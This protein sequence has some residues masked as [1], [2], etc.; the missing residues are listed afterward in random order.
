MENILNILA[1][2]ANEL[3]NNQAHRLADKVTIQLRTASEDDDHE[4][5]MV[6]NQMETAERAI[7]GIEDVIGD[8]GEG[9][10]MA[11]V[12]SKITNAV[13]MLDGVSDYLQSQHKTASDKNK[14]KKL[15]KPFRTP[16]GPKK[17][18]VYVKNDKGNIVKVNFGD[19]GLSIK[20]DNPARRKNFRARHNCDNP[21]P[22]W[23]ARYWSCRNWEAGRSV[24]DNLKGK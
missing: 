1:D 10:L 21:G 13:E 24:S 22:K 8:E 3:D 6:R 11:W 15:N 20:R 19:P 2:L 14:G 17:F 12:Q 7:D 5:D 23:K 9:N 4:Y 18:S 16:G